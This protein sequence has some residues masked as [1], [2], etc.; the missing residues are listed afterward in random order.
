[1]N[2]Q[3]LVVSKGEINNGLFTSIFL[4]EDF[5]EKQVRKTIS[6]IPEWTTQI[7]SAEESAQLVSCIGIDHS[8]WTKWDAIPPKELIPF[9]S[10]HCEATS[11]HFMNLS[12][13]IKR[14]FCFLLKVEIYFFL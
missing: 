9:T 12:D 10:I 14:K 4:T 1:M 11:K 13:Q 6:S 5:D 8:T 2:T 7:G 3:R